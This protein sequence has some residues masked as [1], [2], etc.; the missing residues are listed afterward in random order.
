MLKDNFSPGSAFDVNPRGWIDRASKGAHEF[1]AKGMAGQMGFG[2]MMGFSS[3]Y[4][5][6]KVRLMKSR[7]I[8]YLITVIRLEK[9]WPS[10]QVEYFA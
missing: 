8:L 6:K 9:E 3:G 7:T 5:L 10:L 4:F 2:F 1:V